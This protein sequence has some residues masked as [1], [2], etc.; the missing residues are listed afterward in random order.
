MKPEYLKAYAEMERTKAAYNAIQM[1]N[2]H[3][4]T[5]TVEQR[6][7][8]EV[9]NRRAWNAKYKAEEDW[10]KIIKEL[11]ENEDSYVRQSV[12]SGAM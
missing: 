7:E 1:M 2:V 8:I 3:P 11:A 4:D 12:N 9:A 6:M 5:T 10:N